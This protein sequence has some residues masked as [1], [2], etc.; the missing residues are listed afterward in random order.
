MNSRRKF[1]KHGSM[2]STAL[3]LTKPFETLANRLSPLTGVSI[4]QNKILLVHTSDLAGSTGLAASQLD[5]VKRNNANVLLLNAGE[6]KEP[7]GFDA[8]LHHCNEII[9][10]YK[11]IY[12]GDIKIGIIG[13]QG[14]TND[15][16]AHVNNV[17]AYLK[18]DKS[19]NLVVCLSQLGFKNKS[20]IDDI[21]LASLTEHVDVIIS[22]HQTNYAKNP[23]ILHNLKQEEVIVHS[24]SGKDFV[25]GNIELSF[26]NRRKK[27]HIDFDTLHTA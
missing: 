21:S 22:G 20:A 19:C 25:F 11:I 13:V 16:V 1:L 23:M 5:A 3:L 10:S 18:K 7:N 17:A 14:N 9:D 15:P 2:A 8:S 12:K 4:D 27:R 6:T 26:D 24:S